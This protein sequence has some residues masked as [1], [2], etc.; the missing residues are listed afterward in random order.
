MKNLIYVFIIVLGFGF[1]SCTKIYYAEPQPKD[2][3]SLDAFPEGYSG[4]FINVDDMKDDMSKPSVVFIESSQ[5]SSYE[6]NEISIET[7]SMQNSVKYEIRDSLVYERDSETGQGFPFEVAN[8][9][10]K[11]GYYTQTKYGL[12]DSLVLKWYKDHFYLNYLYEEEGKS[13]WNTILIEQMRDGSQSWWVNNL[14][15]EESLLRKY[16]GL[17]S[18]KKIGGDSYLLN[19]KKKQLHKLV[20]A[21]GF[22]QRAFL[23]VKVEEE[24]EVAEL[25]GVLLKK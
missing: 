6:Y 22:Q 10:V 5:I 23:L 3:A 9:K 25:P 16:V 20:E 14:E 12:S 15:K 11:F 17:N 18:A 13:A 19:P 4:V 24:M 21:G 1:S 8:G 2:V 7:D